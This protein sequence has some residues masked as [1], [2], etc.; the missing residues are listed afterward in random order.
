M[1]A[2][3]SMHKGIEVLF[4]DMP[5]LCG[6]AQAAITGMGRVWADHPL[7]RGTGPVRN[8]YAA[9]GAAV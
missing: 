9:G 8:P 5:C 4:A 1:Q 6:I 2:T 7:R 3:F